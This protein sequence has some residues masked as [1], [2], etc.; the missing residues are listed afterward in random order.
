[1]C[2]ELCFIFVEMIHP[3]IDVKELRF[4]VYPDSLHGSFNDWIA[5]LIVSLK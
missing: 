4:K 3:E 1:M 2:Y 5:C